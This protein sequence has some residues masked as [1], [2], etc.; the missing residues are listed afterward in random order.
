MVYSARQSAMAYSAR[1]SALEY[2]SR[3][4]A[5]EYPSRQGAT[6]RPDAATCLVRQDAVTHQ[7]R[8][9]GLPPERRLAA[10]QRPEDAAQ[11]APVGAGAVAQAAGAGRV[12]HRR[13]SPTDPNAPR[14]PDPPAPAQDH[15]C[16]GLPSALSRRPIHLTPFI[17]RDE[18]SLVAGAFRIVVPTRI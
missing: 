3:Q 13:C 12:I 10:A 18:D 15:H 6:E 8:R 17:G 7:V 14:L 1:Q 9:V 4:G 5:L 11:D 16:F 2:P